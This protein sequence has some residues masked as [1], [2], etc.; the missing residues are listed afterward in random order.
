MGSSVSK[1]KSCCKLYSF[2]PMWGH[3]ECEIH[4]DCTTQESWH[5]YGCDIC[6]HMRHLMQSANQRDK[7]NLLASM[8]YMLNNTEYRLRSKGYLQPRENW[9]FEETVIHF[10]YKF[11]DLNVRGELLRFT[12]PNI[13]TEQ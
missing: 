6:L 13:L 5:P 2:S 7:Q 11:Q 8:L 9:P 12:D 4:R 10:L 1:T 3:Y